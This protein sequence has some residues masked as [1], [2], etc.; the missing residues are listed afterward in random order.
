M[1]KVYCEHLENRIQEIDET[2]DLISELIEKL[3]N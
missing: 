2:L 3:E 1:T